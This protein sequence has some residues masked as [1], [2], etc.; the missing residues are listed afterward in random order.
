MPLPSESLFPFYRCAMVSVSSSQSDKA[1]LH[2]LL[3]YAGWRT[4]TWADQ[5]PCLLEPM[6]VTSFRVQSGSEATD[7]ISQKR[8]DIAV[9]DLGLPLEAEDEDRP[10]VGPGTQTGG[11]RILQILRRLESPPP[12]VVVRRAQDQIAG[13]RTLNEAL[14]EG[15]Y[16]VLEPPVQLE[17]VLEIMRRILRRYHADTWPAGQ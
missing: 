13:Q 2:L 17:H 4:R 11:T 1:R 5:L 3:G 15:A 7:L 9:V 6:G 14:R 16:T 10:A 12:T 8:I